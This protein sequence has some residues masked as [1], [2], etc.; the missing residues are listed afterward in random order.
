MRRRWIKGLGFTLVTMEGMEGAL[1]HPF[2]SSQ[3]ICPLGMGSCRNVD[4][5]EMLVMP[6]GGSK[7]SKD[8]KE[9]K[10]IGEILS[11]G[12]I[13]TTF[14]LIENEKPSE[15]NACNLDPFYLAPS[16]FK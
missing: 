8:S 10:G 11:G 1:Q 9:S 3:D 7:D 2:R 13:A 14:N 5:M 6:M 12:T 15:V 16:G 4:S